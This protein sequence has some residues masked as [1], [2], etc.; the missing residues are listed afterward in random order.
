M[1]DRSCYASI[2][3]AYIPDVYSGD[4][5]DVTVADIYDLRRAGFGI[6]NWAPTESAIEAIGVDAALAATGHIG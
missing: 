2:V 5:G 4:A 1:P 6:G 3:L